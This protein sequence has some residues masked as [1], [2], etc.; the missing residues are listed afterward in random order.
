MANVLIYGAGAIGSFFG[1]LLS[2]SKEEGDLINNVALLGRKSHIQKIKENGLEILFFEGRKNFKFNYCFSNPDELKES[3]FSPQVVVVCVKT[4]SLP[5]VS[6]EIKN[7]SLLKDKLKN[8]DFILLMNGMGNREIFNIP[9]H[10][11]FE[12]ITT[13][14]VVFS[15]D[16]QIELKGKGKTVFESAISQE[17]VSFIERRFEEKGFEVEFAINFKEQQWNKLFVNAVINPIT[18]LTRKKNGIVLSESLRDLVGDIVGECVETAN[19]EGYSF[20]KNQVIDFV[21][22]VALK[23]SGNTSSMLQDVL[24]GRKTEI[25]SI[26]GYVTRLA[27]IHGLKAPANQTLYSLVSSLENEA[28]DEL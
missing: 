11:V 8:A 7:A 27:E 20:D 6:E 13:T 28:A 4:P 3:G 22:S 18:A 12:G 9:S 17:T 14:G 26:S 21:Y 2:E 23:T 24:K 10:N 1:Y 5:A 19:K 25:G 16:G 15:E